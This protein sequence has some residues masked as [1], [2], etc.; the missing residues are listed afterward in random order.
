MGNTRENRGEP[1]KTLD[2]MRKHG[3]IWENTGKHVNTWGTC[4]NLEEHGKT[5]EKIGKLVE[6][7]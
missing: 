3:R 1:Q 5:Q 6:N 4:K 7:M 2:D